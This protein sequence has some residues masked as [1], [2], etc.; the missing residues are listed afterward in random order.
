[1]GPVM[2]QGKSVLAIITARG[3]SKGVP[4]KN[5]RVVGGK[6]LIAY[7]IEAARSSSC[8]D[9]VILSTDDP[10]I[11]EVAARYGCEIPFMR[12]PVLASDEARSADVVLDALVRCPGFDYFV[13]LQPTS[14]L[15]TAADIDACAATC[16]AAG[17]P[18]CVSVSEV[19][20]S[21]FWMYRIGH[22]QTLSAILPPTAAARR[23][24][25]ERIY[26]LNGAVYFADSTFFAKHKTFL[27]PST[28]A[29]I[30]PQERAVD[31]DT[32]TDFNFLEFLIG[33]KANVS[34]S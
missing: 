27:V 5:I 31:L 29:Y 13:L 6:P 24:D 21:P 30:M 9:R 25:L 15:R 20:E 28:I 33:E 18:V 34:I 2:I 11:A 4:R 19:S 10:E 3:G 12:A 26:A 1:M 22:G 7:S 23:Q 14:P 16:L 17:A 32:L 8:V